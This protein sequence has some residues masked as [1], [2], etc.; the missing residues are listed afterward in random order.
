MLIEIKLS[1]DKKAF[2]LISTTLSGIIIEVGYIGTS[3]NGICD[4]AEKASFP[5]L[6]TL[7]GIIVDLQPT[8][9]ELFLVSTI[10]LQSLRLS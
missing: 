2:S 10:A 7:F 1:Q 5:I 4:I 9:R 8:I 6:T 3:A